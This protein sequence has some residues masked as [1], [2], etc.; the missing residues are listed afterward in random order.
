MC[1]LE[2]HLYQDSL[3]QRF[4]ELST[5]CDWSVPEILHWSMVEGSENLSLDVQPLK[6][7]ISWGGDA[8]THLFQA[9]WVK[10]Q[11]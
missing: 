5:G 7:G 8:H 4:Q 11:T 10:S 1:S 6:C 3:A 2:R 9:C